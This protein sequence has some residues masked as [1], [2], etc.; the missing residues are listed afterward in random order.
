MELFSFFFVFRFETKEPVKLVQ[1][2]WMCEGYRVSFFHHLLGCDRK[3]KSHDKLLVTDHNQ[4]SKV[5][6]IWSRFSHSVH[7][8]VRHLFF[9]FSLG[10]SRSNNFSCRFQ[11]F[12]LLS[13][14]QF[15]RSRHQTAFPSHDKY[16]KTF[17]N[18]IIRTRMTATN[19]INVRS[20][21]WCWRH[22]P[23]ICTSIATHMS[24]VGRT[25]WIVEFH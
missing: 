14:A 5:H 15:S 24:A 12:L 13:S 10:V 6:K 4:K 2:L 8:F 17:R 21:A 7:N 22:V 11:F 1:W 19:I 23:R 25:R 18:I 20:M 9:F 3:R 16:P